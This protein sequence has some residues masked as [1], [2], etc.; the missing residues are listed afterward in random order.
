MQGRRI[1]TKAKGP[2]EGK[3][4]SKPELVPPDGGWGWFVVL[5]FALSNVSLI[6]RLSH[7]AQQLLVFGSSD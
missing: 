2:G 1:S 3:A 6:L 7:E 4:A 5:A